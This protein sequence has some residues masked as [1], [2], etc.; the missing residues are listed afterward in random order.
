MRLAAQKSSFADIVSDGVRWFGISLRMVPGCRANAD[1]WRCDRSSVWFSVMKKNIYLSLPFVILLLLPTLVLSPSAQTP[2][3]M[4][5]VL[6]INK[7]LDKRTAIR[8][9]TIPNA[10]NGLFAT[11]LIKKGE[12]IGELGGRFVTGEDHSLGNHYIASLHRCAWEETK[13]Y[14]YLDAKDYGGNV[15]RAN[16]APRKID[17]IETH[18]QNAAIRQLCHFPYFELVAVKDI[19]PGTEIWTSYGPH[20]HYDRFMYAPEV[21]DFFCGKLKIDCGKKYTYEP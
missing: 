8:P 13:P 19:E 20:Y 12:V 18:F 11:V 4:V 3:K 21:R 17:G 5:P 1:T 16:F 15:S 2:G 9:S 7:A 10:G 6:K 14:K